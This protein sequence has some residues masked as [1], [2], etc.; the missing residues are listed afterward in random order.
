MPVK[1]RTRPVNPNYKEFMRSNPLNPA[2]DELIKK[3]PKRIMW[4][5]KYQAFNQ[6]EHIRKLKLDNKF[7]SSL[8]PDT[9]VLEIGSGTGRLTN[10]LLKHSRLQ[11]ENYHLL[12]NSYGENMPW[13]KS[14]VKRLMNQGKIKYFNAN[15]WTHEYPKNTY[16]HIL[17]PENFFIWTSPEYQEHE[18]ITEAKINVL[19]KFVKK[20]EPALKPKGSI[21]ISYI[22]EEAVKQIK[23]NKVLPQ[24]KIISTKG[25]IILQ[26]T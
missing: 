15:M 4:S 20:L 24:F 5:R 7:F 14:R 26:K 25:G 1:K 22:H 17:I 13:I 16:D 23:K 8:K 2:I 3:I 21:R 12:D 19:R 6:E 11:P 9:K 18:G 10:Y